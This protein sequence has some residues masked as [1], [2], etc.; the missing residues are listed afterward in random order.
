MNNVLTYQITIFVKLA[1]IDKLDHLNNV[2]YL[3]WV[4]DITKEY[5]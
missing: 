1:D 4:Q 2:V 3:N 5:W